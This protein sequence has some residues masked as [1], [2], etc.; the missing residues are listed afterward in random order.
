MTDSGDMT[1]ASSE[2]AD[3]PFKVVTNPSKSK[4]LKVAPAQKVVVERTHSFTIRAYFPMPAANTKFH[5]IPNMRAMLE[6]LIKSEPSIVVEH[7]TTPEQIV[8]SKEKIPTNKAVFKQYFMLST[9]T[10]AK[11]NQNHVIIGCKLLSERTMKEIKFDK[12][13]PHFLN[14]LKQEQVFIEADSLGVI[15]TTTI[16]YITKLHPLLTNRTTLKCL[17]QTA[18]EEI[19]IDADLAVELDPTLKAARTQAKTNGDFFNP[20]LPPFEIYKTK[21][22]HGRDKDKVETNVLGIKGTIQQARLLKEFFLQLASPAHYEKQIGVFVPTGAVH[23]VGPTNYANLIRENNIF[24]HSVMT[25]PIGDFQHETLDIPFSVDSTTDIDKTTLLEFIAEQPWC[26]SI[27]KTTT[28][29]KVLI[30]TTK[31]QLITARQWIDTTL[32]TIYSQFIA[33]KI[34]VTTLRN[35][36]PRHLDKPVLTAASTTYANQ[37]KARTNNTTSVTAA[38]KQFAKPPRPKTTPQVDIIFDDKDFP[39][40]ASATPPAAA[41]Q[42]NQPQEATPPANATPNPNTK[43]YDYK[44]KW[45]TSRLLLRIT[46]NNN[47]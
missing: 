44:R 12:T 27:E 20:A 6:A 36:T 37:L 28:T 43:P 21:L 16:G 5:P 32:P 29:N 17:L 25:I 18:L 19:V 3:S 30:T 15:K 38:T 46:S 22:N 45:I 47:S 35:L 33:D 34:D 14:W 8:L 26:L 1:M 4:R 7:S 11:K 23:L 10:R 9:E 42:T 2:A 41:P 24:I 13:R 40:L 31:E 39:P